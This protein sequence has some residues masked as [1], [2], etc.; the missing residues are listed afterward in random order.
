MPT[1]KN[2]PFNVKK[3][4]DPIK[5]LLNPN[6]IGKVAPPVPTD[7]PTSVPGDKDETTKFGYFPIV[8]ALGTGLGAYQAPK[9]KKLEG[10]GRGAIRGLST[11]LG[12]GVGGG[13]GAAAGALTGYGLSPGMVQFPNAE[14]EAANA[15]TQ[16]RTSLGMGLGGLAGIPLGGLLG[17]Y[18]SGK[19]LGKPS[20]ETEKEDNEKQSGVLSNLFIAK[21]LGLLEGLQLPKEN[22]YAD[23]QNDLINQ[24]ANHHE[25]MAEEDDKEEQTLNTLEEISPKRNNKKASPDTIGL[26]ANK[27]TSLDPETEGIKRELDFNTSELNKI[28]KRHKKLM[29][30]SSNPKI[31]ISS[32]LSPDNKAT[33][34]SPYLN[35]MPTSKPKMKINM[36]PSAT[37]ITPSLRTQEKIARIKA[38]SPFCASFLETALNQGYLYSDLS[39]LIIKS[40]KVNPEMVGEWEKV[41]EKLGSLEKEAE[42]PHVH[43]EAPHHIAADPGMHV[44]PHIALDSPSLHLT[45][46]GHPIATVENP[47]RP[48]TY[49]QLVSTEKPGVFKAYPLDAGGGINNSNPVGDVIHDNGSFKFFDNS[50]GAPRNITVSADG[51]HGQKVSLS[52]MAYPVEG[53]N[54]KYVVDVSSQGD[55]SRFKQVDMVGNKMLS[56]A[57]DV[58]AK[59]NPK[60]N[61]A[62]ITPLTT[63]AGNVQLDGLA[64]VTPQQAMEAAK[65]GKP[66]E[67]K[68]WIDGNAT[69]MQVSFAADANG[70]PTLSNATLNSGANPIY[71]QGNATGGLQE[72]KAPVPQAAPQVSPRSPFNP[73]GLAGNDVSLR[74]KSLQGP[75]S[76][77]ERLSPKPNIAGQPA[78]AAPAAPQATAP[79]HTPSPVTPTDPLTAARETGKVMGQEMLKGQ[80]SKL[81]HNLAMWS[82][83]AIAGG[84]TAVGLA[85]RFF[86]DTSSMSPEEIMAKD[87]DFNKLVAA[88]GAQNPDSGELTSA[89][90][91]IVQKRPYL[92][93]VL[94]LNGEGASTAFAMELAKNPMKLDDLK[95]AWLQ[96]E[97]MQRMARYSADPSASKAYAEKRLDFAK[98]VNVKLPNLPNP[99]AATPTTPTPQTPAT[100]P[101]SETGGWLNNIQG[102]LGQLSPL[103][104]AALGI[105][106]PAAGIGAAG[107]IGNIG[108]KKTKLWAPLLGLGGLAAAGYGLSGG[109]PGKLLNK[110]FWW[111]S[112]T[113]PASAQPSV[114]APTSAPAQPPTPPP[115]SNPGNT[116]V[117]DAKALTSKLDV[118]KD[119]VK[120]S[121]YNPLRWNIKTADWSDAFGSATKLSPMSFGKTPLLGDS[122]L[123]NN[124]AAPKL[125]PTDLANQHAQEA[126]Q[127]LAKVQPFKPSITETMFKPNMPKVQNNV[128]TPE[129]QPS[130][131]ISPQQASGAVTGGLLQTPPPTMPKVQQPVL[132]QATPPKPPGGLLWNVG[133]NIYNKTLGK[134]EPTSTPTPNPISNV[135]PEQQQGMSNVTGGL[136][137]AGLHTKAQ[138]LGI[139]LQQPQPQDAEKVTQA[140]FDDLKKQNYQPGIIETAW[141]SFMSMPWEQKLMIGLGLL[142]GTVGIGSMLSGGGKEEG[143]MNIWGPL[144]GIGGLAAA[145]YGSGMIPGF[146]YN[147]NQGVP[148]YVQPEDFSK[149]DQALD[150]WLKANPDLGKS[151]HG[152][153]LQ[154]VVQGIQRMSPQSFEKFQTQLSSQYGGKGQQL[155]TQWKAQAD[156]ENAREKLYNEGGLIDHLGKVDLSHAG[157]AQIKD[158]GKLFE[159][160]PQMSPQG[161]N[162][163]VATLVPAVGKVSNTTIGKALNNQLQAY[164]NVSNDPKSLAIAANN[165]KENL[166]LITKDPQAGANITPEVMGKL[167]AALKQAYSVPPEQQQQYMQQL[168]T[169]YGNSLKPFA[170]NFYK[171]YGF[172]GN[173]PQGWQPPNTVDLLGNSQQQTAP[174]T[175][176]TLTGG[177]AQ[178]AQPP[179]PPISNPG[180]TKPNSPGTVLDGATGV[181]GGLGTAGALTQNPH[182]SVLDQDVNQ[183]AQYYEQNI[184]PTLAK[185]PMDQAA[186]DNLAKSIPS[187]DAKVQ[188][189]TKLYDKVYGGQNG[190]FSKTTPV[191]ANNESQLLYRLMQET[192]N[193]Q[194]QTTNPNYGKFLPF[195]NNAGPDG[196]IPFDAYQNEKQYYENLTKDPK[197]FKQI[198]ANSHNALL[199][200][201]EFQTGKDGKPDLPQLTGAYADPNTKTFD[202]IRRAYL[203]KSLEQVLQSG[204][205]TDPAVMN[206]LKLRAQLRGSPV[207]LPN[208]S[209]NNLGINGVAPAGFNVAT[210]Y[211]RQGYDKNEQPFGPEEYERM[212]GGN[213]NRFGLP[214]NAAGYDELARAVKAKDPSYDLN[215]QFLRQP[216]L[217]EKYKD[218]KITPD[219]LAKLTEGKKMDQGQDIYDVFRNIPEAPT[220]FKNYDAL[221]AMTG[222]EPPQMPGP[223][224]IFKYRDILKT[225]VNPVAIAQLAR[226]AVSNPEGYKAITNA[227]RLHTKPMGGVAGFFDTK[228]QS[229]AMNEGFIQQNY[230]KRLRGELWEK[231]TGQTPSDLPKLT[232][233]QATVILKYLD[234]MVHEKDYK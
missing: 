213:Y 24:I 198:L 155:A 21:K 138:E 65:T 194:N 142:A 179:A 171:A 74:S 164:A 135:T 16:Q 93:K 70:H 66:L 122:P 11:E 124:A 6:N 42:L 144:L 186:I 94:N 48:G 136:G 47:A 234:N 97:N 44:A 184:L 43:I 62:T 129:P 91:Q 79:V 88:A 116:I 71:L 27:S 187:F 128:P 31:K 61:L 175:A 173:P 123:A 90:N 125:D 216:G 4:T 137:T 141:N 102:N 45:E 30:E 214:V 227:Q 5:S 40:A 115:V 201:T 207:N 67:V 39:E 145:A 8:T 169:E 143:G 118:L 183:R 9:K 199:T 153:P 64:N 202:P 111:K 34:K 127:N 60:T 188:L 110:D 229:R 101:A 130:T 146:G 193:L 149:G 2:K 181:L 219:L 103:H 224:D 191:L 221:R 225:D 228:D 231:L 20:W 185:G 160:V 211:L 210:Q 98:N 51:P 17:Y 180:N 37:E 96:D 114:E 170:D 205:V 190:S 14:G 206:A 172:N 85:P 139:N 154:Q 212:T 197:A 57:I 80:P 230:D 105:G 140:V 220:V 35:P 131:N 165:L 134:P 215:N 119:N 15:L 95:E 112:P 166:Q 147:Q 87:P 217:A 156:Y 174:P 176:A 75:F 152:Q 69:K 92:A 161:F 18:L 86:G 89:L 167:S 54:G 49:V 159:Q 157:P 189:A 148:N 162:L 182:V 38:I 120:I 32:F 25:Q 150:S 76:P 56:S 132:P 233:D 7:V 177:N 107:T 72:T 59:I 41:F 26:L 63:S 108:K 226:Y 33:K 113:N 100:P 58:P 203:D 99:S 46:Y 104:L 117:P 29:K 208:L 73:P 232:N 204:D 178:P 109:D 1:Y 28:K 209:A 195:T 13:L 50:H 81:Q 23:Y 53:Q 55:G 52:R 106:L 12:L 126:H 78:P 68:A 84:A 200:G 223:N 151:L 158:F 218:A 82:L 133:Q 168:E 77:P 22:V 3:L 36:A 163:A 10:A 19:A 196:K 222:A 83:P 192:N 121:A